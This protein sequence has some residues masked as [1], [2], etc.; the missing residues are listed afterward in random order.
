[1]M[2]I[3]RSRLSGLSC[4]AT[5]AFALLLPFE[6]KPSPPAGNVSS[7]EADARHF[8]VRDSIEMS[9]F[10]RIDYEPIPSPDGQYTAA[11]TSRGLV[12]NDEVES[13]L[14][15]FSTSAIQ[16]SLAAERNQADLAPSV[17][18]RFAATPQAIYHTPYEPILSDVQWTKDSR[19]LLFLVQNASGRRQIY[20]AVLGEAKAIAITPPDEDVT[21]FDSS[22]GTVVYRVQGPLD[23]LG[24]QGESINSD[25]SDVTGLTLPSILFPGI[26]NDFSN[27]FS[28]LWFTRGG[29]NRPVLDPASGLPLSLWNY[30]PPIWNVLSISPDGNSV[31]VLL[32]VK[33]VP[34]SWD[35]YTPSSSILAIH[36]DDPNLVSE[37][38]PGRL[39]QYALIDLSTGRART[40]IHAPNGWALGYSNRNRA[41]WSPDG[42]ALLVTNSFLPFDAADDS[43]N[44]LRRRPCTAAVANLP[45]GTTACLSYRQSEPLAQSSF[46]P[47]GSEVQLWFSGQGTPERYRLADGSWQP[48]V[49]AAEPS[50]E[51]PPECLGPREGRKDSQSVYVKRSLNEPPT[52]WATDCAA[53]RRIEIWNP[54]PQLAGVHLGEASVIRWKDESGYAWK[55]ALLLPPDYV[56]GKRYPL[57]IQAYGF[58]ENE[59]L[60]DGEFTTA[61]AARPLAAAGMIVL[62]ITERVDSVGTVEEAPDQVLG[63]ESA[64]NKLSADGLIDRDRVGIIGFS[65]TSYYVESALI[66]HPEQFAAATIADGVDESYLQYL[67]FWAVRPGRKTE[68]E[69]M[70]GSVPFGQ[71]LKVWIDHAPGFHLDRIETPLRIQAIGPVSLLGEWEIYASL[72]RQEKPVDLVYF[73]HGQHILQRPLDRMASEQ[74][75][76]DW[77]RFWLN[78]E[79]DA[80]PSKVPQYAIWRRIRDRYLREKRERDISR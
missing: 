27:T 6:L 49:G 52:L 63:F 68:D 13:T 47:T 34:R 65:R 42:R 19:G 11:V 36:S 31:A 37:S 75:D 72:Y 74:G 78:G 61:F 10:G 62:A 45:S 29:K 64:I 50:R 33:Q 69:E 15:V 56:A 59:F 43:E 16:K 53:A 40:I 2:V 23:A 54:N 26:Q 46:G 41:T 60:S 44:L 22:A 80:D 51:T 38:N 18:A 3:K 58:A 77:F 30:P 35:R 73:P 24:Q 8:T 71:G 4:A 9:R 76:V 1:M 57:V 55:G 67:L 79:E 7:K 25:A 70:Y 12:E 5:L 66:S 17:V 48:E 21:Q 28:T 20:H 39:T 14:R 32:P